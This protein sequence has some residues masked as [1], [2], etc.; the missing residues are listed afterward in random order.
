MSASASGT[1]RGS[2]AFAIATGP[3]P[4]PLTTFIMTYAAA[5]GAVQSGLLLSALFATGMTFTVALFPLTAVL[6]R[7]RL[8]PL[9]ARSETVRNRVAMGL[10]TFAAIAVIM[11]GAWPL[12]SNW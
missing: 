8:L 6:G 5:H 12:V 2:V 11:L 3:I 10:E 9:I 7:T 1:Q 4:C